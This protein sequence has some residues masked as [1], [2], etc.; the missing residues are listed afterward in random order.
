MQPLGIQDS[1]WSIGYGRAYD[2]DGLSL[3]ANWGGAAFTPRAAAKLA[4]LM[5]H[6]GEWTHQQLISRRW[7]E[8]AVTYVGTP[9]PKGPLDANAPASGLCWWVNTNGGW[10]GIPT[11]AFAGAGAGHQIVLV[12]PSL[13]LIVVRNGQALAL[14][15]RAHG[16]WSPAVQYLLRPV[17]EAITEKRAY[18]PSP[19]IGGI[20]F[21]DSTGILRKALGSDN[22]PITWGDDDRQ[23]AAYGDVNCFEPYAD[24]KLSQ[25]FAL[26]E[27]SAGDIRGVN[28]RSATGERMGNGAKGPKA[29]GMLMVD[30]VLYLWVRNAHNAQLA[31]S[32]DHGKTW[33]WRFRFP[34]GFG[35]P[36]FLNFGKNYRGARDKY[37]YTYSQDGASAYESDDSLLLARVAKDRLRDRS[38]WEFLERLDEHG[39]PV[40]TADIGRRGEV[41]RYPRHCRR[42]DGVYDAALKRYLLAV[43][44]D[45]ESGWGIYDAPEP[46]GPWTTAFHTEHWDFDHTHGYR[47]PAKWIEGDG[48]AMALVFSGLAPY[49][50][51]CVRR[52]T[53]DTR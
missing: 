29:S 53:L 39:T 22:W 50:A 47:L 44:Y 40:W 8:Q 9:L 34:S 2:T 20:H 14:P 33:E 46:W 4:S 16:F 7:V 42:V 37:V 35:S 21:T 41:F 6:R 28:I 1:A 30:G 31:W 48:R 38:S 10:E 5:L 15:D 49:D 26:I 18:P 17:V 51:F 27:G 24:K 25:G 3:Y 11:D 43:A 13:D 52:M 19:V 12:V 23:Y 32:A 36:A 45:Q